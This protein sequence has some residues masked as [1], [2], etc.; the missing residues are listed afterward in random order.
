VNIRGEEIIP[1]ATYWVQAE[2]PGKPP[3]EWPAPVAMSTWTYGDVAYPPDTNVGV[4]DI[5]AIIAG[6]QQGFDVRAD[7]H[8]CEP[9]GVN[10][11]GDILADIAIYQGATYAEKCPTPCSP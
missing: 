11:V 10:G 3:A 8:P 4:Q 1:S 5:M 6:Y 9:D 2:C 7:I